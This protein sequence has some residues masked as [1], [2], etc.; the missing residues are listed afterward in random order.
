MG[1]VRR[2]WSSRCSRRSREERGSA[3]PR[4]AGLAAP[5]PTPVLRRGVERT[6]GGARQQPAAERRAAACG[7]VGRRASGA[8]AVL[9]RPMS[10][11]P[12]SRLPPIVVCSEAQLVFRDLGRPS[13]QLS[14]GSLGQSFH[15]FLFQSFH[16]FHFFLTPNNPSIKFKKKK[17]QS[18]HRARLGHESHQLV[19]AETRRKYGST[20]S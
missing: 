2:R 5:A 16:S 9:L 10:P 1:N 13:C 20:I 3:S 17:K 18:F 6:S 14:N 4:P 8:R 7:G 12:S 11:Q 19:P 15:R